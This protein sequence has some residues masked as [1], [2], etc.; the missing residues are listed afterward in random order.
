MLDNGILENGGAETSAVLKIKAGYASLS[1]EGKITPVKVME[2]GYRLFREKF[3]PEK[4]KTLD[5]E[6]LLE[7]MFNVSNKD[8][9]FYWLEFKNDDIFNTYTYGSIGGGSAFKYIIFKRSA[10]SKWVTG[11]PQ[12]PTVLSIDNAITLGRLIRDALTKGC[13][14]ISAVRQSAEPD[15]YSK[16]KVRLG[17]VL[18]IK[19]IEKDLSAFGW[20]HKYYHMIFPDAIDNYHSLKWQRHGLVSLGIKPLSDNFYEL[21]GQYVKLAGE[22]DIPLYY[23]LSVLG[24]LAGAPI[25]YYRI[26]TTAGDT[27]QSY[28]ND[29]KTGG[30]V[31]IGWSKLG[32]LRN[33]PEQETPKLREKLIEMLKTYYTNDN[34][35]IGRTASQFI[36]FYKGI[37]ERDVVIAGNGEKT[38][39]IGYVSG[40]YEYKQGFDFPHTI[41][42]DWHYVTETKLPNPKEGLRTTV[43]QYKDIDNIIEIEKLAN[44]PLEKPAEIEPDITITVLPPLDEIAAEING[45]LSRKNQVI[46]Y[47]PPGTGKT[48]H[49]ERISLELASRSHFNKTFSALTYTEKDTICG[50]EK[51]KGAVRI[52]CFHPSY[53]YEDFIEGIRPAAQNDKTVFNLENGIFKELCLDAAKQPDKNFYLII[54][55]INRGDIS[56]IFGELIMLIENGKRE[57]KLILPLSKEPFFVPQNVY[58]VGTMNTADR[59]IAL[60]DVALRR[61][62]GFVELMPDYGFFEGVVFDGLPLARWLEDL[63]GRICENIGRDSRNLQIGHAYFLEKGK[64]VSDHSVFKRIIKEDIIPLIEEYCYGDYSALAKIL[65]ENLVD[66]KKQTVNYSLFAQ[67]DIADLVS[68]LLA[69][70]PELRSDREESDSDQVQGLDDGDADD[71]G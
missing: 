28:W 59:S 3:A 70:C 57:K 17:E 69:P 22:C 37:K 61:R 68:A 29:M 7:T 33:Y 31:S 14:E 64:P 43:Y 39:G 54:D 47:G 38:L 50:T 10:D 18:Y 16:L 41:K 56:R 63:N 8:G 44:M 20:V 45:T 12:T 25:N 40:G 52:C 13:V 4:L 30:Y 49:A 35:A 27:G 26:G 9:L 71:N 19:D 46:L 15:R 36:S 32:D 21:A 5:G 24:S 58:I 23:F 67:A 11:N 62:F 42:V 60:L 2:Q 34:R 66:V 65:G 1:A 55:E 51:T 53:G 6:L 48:Y